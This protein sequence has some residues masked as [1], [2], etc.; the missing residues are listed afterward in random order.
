MSA[1]RYKVD[2]E[3]RELYRQQLAATQRACALLLHSES[4]T[5]RDQVAMAQ[6]A[7]QQA[8]HQQAA[9]AGVTVPRNGRPPSMGGGPPP[10][11]SSLPPNA[12]P[13]G[14]RPLSSSQPMMNGMLS[15]TGQMPNGY[16]GG[17]GPSS[18]QQAQMQALMQG[19]A[20][21]PS[22]GGQDTARMIME[23]SRLNEQQRLQAQRQLAAASG[24]NPPS[25]QN[26]A[27]IG[28]P[29]QPSAAMMASAQAAS[30]KLSPANGVGTPQPRPSSS[31]RSNNGAHA[32][33]LSSG[34][35]PVLNQIANQLR[36]MHPHA[37]PDQ[38]KQMATSHLSQSLRSSNPP[39]SMMGGG[40]G[41]ANGMGAAGTNGMPQLSPQAQPAALAAAAAAAY[42]SPGMNSQLYAQYMRSQQASQQSRLGDGSDRGSL[43][44][45]SRG[46]TPAHGSRTSQ[47]PHIPHAQ[48]TG[49]S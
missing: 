35:V 48:M 40:G 45:E 36:S 14:Q 49:S 17:R 31:P 12:L 44:P 19:Q 21:V 27:N 1:H 24:F 47:S 25:S 3:R 2:C 26:M 22:Q 46:A 30:G 11:L 37:S 16:M 9:A 15:S 4:T 41:T 7:V 23:A 10:H 20:R 32:G 38:I 6:K 33:S 13:P 39:P 43:R 29:M 42:G 28:L 8:T 18:V 34:T 5:D